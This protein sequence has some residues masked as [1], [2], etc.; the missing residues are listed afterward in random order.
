MPLNLGEE[1][2]GS[3][4]SVCAHR[5]LRHAPFSSA[6]LHFS[7]DQCFSPPPHL[8]LIGGAHSTKETEEARG[9][10][11]CVMILSGAVEVLRS[12]I[13]PHNQEAH[14]QPGGGGRGGGGGGGPAEIVV[15]YRR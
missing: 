14:L 10:H 5:R 2:D 12:P 15:T 3:C 6:F 8:P 11:N 7:L 4:H 1:M 13:A 9:T